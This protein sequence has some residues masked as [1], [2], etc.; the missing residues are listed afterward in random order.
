MFSLHKNATWKLVEK[1]SGKKVIWCRWT[2][3]KKPGILGVEPARYKATV[4]AKGFS[5]VE[6]IDYHDIFSPVVK[7]SSIR[8]L[9][10]CTTMFDF[11]LDKL[12][13]KTTFLRGTLDE[14]IYMHKQLGFVKRGDEDKVCLL[15]KSCMD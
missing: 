4:V 11:E 2:F 9:L 15:L 3:R 8:L 10:G 14:V 6:G 5:Q 7:H 1:S 13:V 12:D